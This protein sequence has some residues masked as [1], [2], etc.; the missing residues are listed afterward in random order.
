MY[1]TLLIAFAA[2]AFAVLPLHGQRCFDGQPNCVQPPAPV[3]ML[4]SVSASPTNVHP[5]E[6]VTLVA[7]S[8][9][10]QYA[11]PGAFIFMPSPVPIPDVFLFAGWDRVDSGGNFEATLKTTELPAGTTRVIVRCVSCVSDSLS[12]SVS[13]RIDSTVALAPPS[14]L[15]GLPSLFEI[16]VMPSP[17]GRLPQ[18]IYGGVTVREG[19]Q[20]LAT[21]Q[22][23]G[24]WDR[25]GT[26]ALTG[27]PLSAGAHALTVDYEGNDTFNPSSTTVSYVLQDH[28]RLSI[29]TSPYPFSVYGQPVTFTAAVDPPLSIPLVINDGRSTMSVDAVRG[30]ATWSSSSITGGPHWFTVTCSGVPC[31]AATA[32][33]TVQPPAAK[34]AVNATPSTAAGHPTHLDVAVTILAQPAEGIVEISENDVLL[35]T[36]S[37]GNG[38][39]ALDVGPLA[40]G[41]HVLIVRYTGSRDELSV[42]E[43]FAHTVLEPRVS[44]DSVAAAEGNSGS[45][46]VQVVLRLSGADVEPLSVAWKTVDRTAVAGRDY[47]AASGNA[48]F[49][50]GETAKEIELEIL[51]NTTPEREKSFAVVAGDAE[52]L[53]RIVNDD[54]FYAR[55]RALAYGSAPEQTLDLLVPIDRQGPF[56][57]IV[58]I[59]ASEFIAPDRDCTITAREAERGYAVAALSFRSAEIAPFPAQLDDVQAALRWLRAHASEYAIDATR[60]GVWGI[61]AGGHL[62]AL[63]ATSDDAKVQAAVDWFGEIDFTPLGP[64]PR[65]VRYLGC[66]PAECP[67]IASAANAATHVSAGDAPLLMMHGARDTAVPVWTTQSL[68]FALLSAGVDARIRIVDGADHGGAAWIDPAV[69]DLVDAFFDEKLNM[70][71]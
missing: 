28:A 64:A 2:A 21:G 12:A 38:H 61:G 56:P 59:E 70:P 3:C 25:G 6:P 68:Y 66:A 71:R 13:V 24:L 65:Y 39:A 10:T 31:D 69:L 4:T 33:L 67:L 48:V 22:L 42:T 44:V 8:H 16:T 63:V 47:I 14:F 36:A 30:S 41:E 53:V 19:A 52:G 57:L 45:K 49:A 35:G 37:L 55:H 54:A 34:I 40:C 1:R 15:A 20:V 17:F 62:A 46:R 9:C 58:A 32:M 43:A 60:I 23:H 26:I 29:R 50:A 51:G 11:S 5:G 18:S 27:P 7:H